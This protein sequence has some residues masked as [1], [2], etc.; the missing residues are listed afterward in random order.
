MEANV[1][2]SDGRKAIVRGASREDIVA[3][4]EEYEASL[5][6]NDS[7]VSEPVRRGA[8]A[9]GE[10]ALV[11]VGEL[12]LS[13]GSGVV[14]EP[15]SGVMGIGRALRSGG[16]AGGQRVEELRN[17]MTYQPRTPEGQRIQQGM[18]D[19]VE[20]VADFAGYM[21]D[22]AGGVGAA[23]G[24]PFGLEAEGDSAGRTL[25]S[26]AAMLAGGVLGGGIKQ[27]V[28]Q[29]AQT[30]SRQAAKI[31][32][33]STD[34]SLAK[35]TLKNGKVTPDD[36]AKEVIRQ[37]VDEGVVAVIKQGSVR[38]K[39]A[40]RRMVSTLEKSQNNRRYAALHRPSDVVGRTVMARANH[41]RGINQAARK[42][43]D[44]VSRS[45]KGKSID[46]DDAVSTFVDDLADM[47]ATIKNGKVAY[48]KDADIPKGMRGIV[49]QVVE[50][51]S[52][53]GRP[54]AHAAHRLKRYIDELVAYGRESKSGLSG[55]TE[56]IIKELRHSVDAKLDE[57]FPAYNQA[58]TRYADT[59]KALS[60]LQD[61]A[62]KKID[63][64]GPSGEAALGRL[65][66]R[67]F[68]NAQSRERLMESLDE[69]DRVAKRYGGTFD[70]DVITQAMFAQELE[71]RFGTTATSS[72]QG[73]IDKVVERRLGQL[74][75]GTAGAR[76][77]VI[78][79]LGQASDKVR[80]INDEA[81]MKALKRLLTPEQSQ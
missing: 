19:L 23:V 27:T 36:L 58:N 12:A 45:L 73:D 53:G 62:G 34:K 41:V 21:S 11:G 26:G 70:D 8:N 66:R 57:A 10:N 30:A 64:T 4:V 78:E 9:S 1:K 3:K 38:D 40:M 76:N 50:R 51:M 7:M 55:R 63:L 32:A 60:D 37:G 16:Q 61:I 74:A 14:A 47:G 75:D 39:L 42:E 79:K 25:L 2:F 17:A 20:P 13:I 24:R 28:N 81:A 18:A 80:G 5:K 31:A 22:K 49:N 35:V 54:D 15:V 77:F 6:P 56:S 33:K 69:L 43:L 59:I 52:A 71:R 46:V 67:I 72:F 48:A 68:G 44:V 65:S 29:S